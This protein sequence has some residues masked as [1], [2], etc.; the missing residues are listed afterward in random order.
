MLRSLVGRLRDHDF[1]IREVSYEDWVSEL[2]RHAAANPSHPM[3]PFLPLFLDRDPD[4]GLTIAEMYFEHVFPHYGRANLEQA[5]AGS[6]IA[7][8]AVDGPLLDTV[9]DRLIATGFLRYRAP[10]QRATDQ[11]PGRPAHAG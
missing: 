3:T 1:A 7:F 2:L 6:G 4:T 5:L 8:P 10:A 9:I 11:V